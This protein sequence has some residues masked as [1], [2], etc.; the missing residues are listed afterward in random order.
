MAP[1]ASTSSSRRLAS[2][3]ALATTALVAGNAAMRDQRADACG[4]SGPVIEDLTTFDPAVTGELGGAGLHYDPYVAGFGGP[5]DDCARTAMAADWGAYFGNAVAAADWDKVLYGAPS[6]DLAAL[7]AAVASG[8]KAP[9][10]WEALVNAVANRTSMRDP[11]VRALDYVALARATEAY[12]SFDAAPPSAAEVKR[13]KALATVGEKAAAKAGDGF[14]AQR[15]AFQQ[16]RLAFYARDWQAAIA[17]FDARAA[18]LAKPSADLAGR[19]RYYA[20]GAL[21]QQGDLARANLELA[22]VHGTTPA[23]A[24]VAAQ[25]FQP[26]ED[27][28]WKATLALAKDTRE[29]TELWRLV[30]FK[31]DGIAAA[32]EIVKLDPT[33]NLLGLLAV[34]ELSR[35]EAN[36]ST[37]MGPPD[38]T[39]VAAAQ[40]AAATLEQLATTLAATPGVD[41]PWLLQLVAG[42][43]AARRGDLKAARTRLAAAQALRPTDAKVTAQA[44]ASL[45]LALAQTGPLGGS[46]GDELGRTMIAVGPDFGR[47]SAL[48]AEIRYHLAEVALKA[49]RPVDAEFLRPDGPATAAQWTDAKFL[50][51]MIARANKNATAFDRFV[52]GGSYTRAALEQ[53]LALRNLLDGKFAESAQA[54]AK[55]AASAQLGTDPFITHIVDC[56]DCDH[57]TYGSAPWTHASMVARMAKLVKQANGKGQ[58]AADA[59]LELGNAFYNL[60]WYGNARVVLDGTHQTTRDTAMAA[61]WY[62][63]AYEQGKSREF[64]A[65][66][67]FFAAKAELHGLIAKQYQPYEE[68]S[69]LPV[70]TTWYPVVKTF[71]DTQYYQDVLRECGTYAA[72]ARQ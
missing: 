61:R 27:K 21:R 24:G 5:C 53:E 54:F 71:A 29:R 7:R 33:S 14:L 69:V 40:K 26:M 13:L 32:Q 63:R 68:A 37:Q 60:T 31:L 45:A 65:K 43:L 3:I 64:K 70:P 30:G 62:K 56:H 48:T 10:G 4:W 47:R 12:T 41:R 52:T 16:V 11:V 35:I 34:R 19:A 8:G 58:A 39:T 72:W 51:Q 38:P 25:D 42:H 67:A 66:A 23:L 28:D 18:V 49:G 15:F 46:L 17:A 55:G 1:K 36:L 50:K 59:A 57:A 22:R 9:R 20:A 44:R 2:T 6:R